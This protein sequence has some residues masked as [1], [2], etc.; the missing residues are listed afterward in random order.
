MDDK[1]LITINKVKQHN[2]L[3]VLIIFASV[4]MVFGINGLSNL[5]VSDRSNLGQILLGDLFEI[6]VISGILKG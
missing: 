2:F 3:K 6:I 4:G 5:I 1:S